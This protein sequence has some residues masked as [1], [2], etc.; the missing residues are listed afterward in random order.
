MDFSFIRR[1][2]GVEPDLAALLVTAAT[3][4]ASPTARA[5][6]RLDMQ[7]ATSFPA[8][9][10]VSLFADAQLSFVTLVASFADLPVAVFRP[11]QS[12]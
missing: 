3:Q 11:R 12:N 9:P 7:G 2:R 1:H 10:H 6:F 8:D 4:S 5:Q